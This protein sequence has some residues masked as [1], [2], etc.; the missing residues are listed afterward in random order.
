MKIKEIRE[1]TEEEL[2]TRRRQI[3]QELFN[4]RMQQQ[5]GQLQK[6]SQIRSLRH[7]VARIETV[8]TERARKA[9]STASTTH[10]ASAV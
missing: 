2:R 6:S 10:A 9:T 3:K 4:L 8:L 7:D 5:A 1:L